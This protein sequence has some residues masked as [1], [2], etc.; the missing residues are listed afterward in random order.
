MAERDWTMCDKETWIEFRT[1]VVAGIAR[2]ELYA[3]EKY[4][5]K[6]FATDP[7]DE[8][9]AETLDVLFYVWMERRRWSQSR[10]NQR[11]V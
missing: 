3:A 10:Q 8:L 7:L 2:R 9:W 5:Y 11:S 6:P 4:G 1:D